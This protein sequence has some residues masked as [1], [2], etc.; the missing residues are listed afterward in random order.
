MNYER[1]EPMANNELKI[2]YISV[3]ALKLYE[4]NAKKHPDKQIEN[5]VNS[6]REFGF[7]F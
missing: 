7:V 3:D 2:E 4:K 1:G 5:I 6:I